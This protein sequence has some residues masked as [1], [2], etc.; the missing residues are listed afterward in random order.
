MGKQAV[1]TAIEFARLATCDLVVDATYRGGDSGNVT[2]DPLNRL[3]RTE[4][5]NGTEARVEFDA[6][7]SRTSDANDTVLS[8]RW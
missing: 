7:Q 5:P 8:S 1:T 3:I 4:F 2:D 6:W